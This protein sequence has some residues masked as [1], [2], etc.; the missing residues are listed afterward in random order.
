MNK[1]GKLTSDV[2]NESCCDG[3]SGNSELSCQPC[4]CDP[5]AKWICL[6]HLQ[7][8]NKQEETEKMHGEPQVRYVQQRF[9]V[10]TNPTQPTQ[11]ERHL[12]DVVNR[13]WNKWGR[14]DSHEKE[15]MNAALGLAGEAGES[16]DV[17][18]K[19][20]FHSAKPGK[21]EEQLLDLKKELG[22]VYFY[23]LK[24]QDLFGITTEEVLQLNREKLEA[25]HPGKIG[26]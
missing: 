22:D 5:K 24:L 21:K 20:Y 13:C 8:S 19:M 25:R 11:L 16:A 9:D 18:K 23:L 2:F 6:V 4:G 15:V 1:L 14:C 17:V 7:R 26:A 3:G 12:R 10:E